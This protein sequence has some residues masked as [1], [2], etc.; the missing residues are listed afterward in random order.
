MIGAFAISDL[1]HLVGPIRGCLVIDAVMSS[2]LL[3]DGLKLL[4]R[5][6]R[7][8]GGRPSSSCEDEADDGDAARACI[9]QKESRIECS[10]LP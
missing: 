3:L 10:C 7:N 6:R 9:D 1:Q 8:N 5:R 2:V 4:I